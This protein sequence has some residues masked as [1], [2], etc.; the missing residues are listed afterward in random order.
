MTAPRRPRRTA[1]KT[2]RPAP[3]AQ[4]PEPPDTAPP[5]SEPPSPD[6]PHPLI[7]ALIHRFD[8]QDRVMVNLGDDGDGDG[9]PLTQFFESPSVPNLVTLLGYLAGT[10]EYQGQV[11]QVLYLDPAAY[12]WLLVRDDGIVNRRRQRDRT[13][14][15]GYRDWICVRTDATVAPG[16]GHGPV[17]SLLTGGFVSA[18]DFHT[19]IS[20]GTHRG[21]GGLMTEAITPGCCGRLS[22]G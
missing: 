6:G 22:H 8:Q 15:Y 14:A 1:A 11:W 10:I 3:P 7:E 4:P 20:G 2:A 21:G 13:A 18:G 17:E 19:A 16:R 9:K 5:E 12:K